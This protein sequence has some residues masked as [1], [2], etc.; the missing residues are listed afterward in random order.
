MNKLF[1][2]FKKLGFDIVD[3]C[4]VEDDWHNFTALNIPQDHPARDMQDTF[5]ITDN[6]LL[7][8]HTS[9]GQVRT[10]KNKKPPIKILSPGKVYRS[11]D[12]ASHSPMFHQMEGLVVDKN[13]SLCD[14]KGLLNKFFKTIFDEKSFTFISYKDLS[15]SIAFESIS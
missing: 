11:D 13:V 3:G 7:R 1:S 4:E 2:I 15:N 12:D 6:I 9:P 8:P 5:Y 14:L 10:M